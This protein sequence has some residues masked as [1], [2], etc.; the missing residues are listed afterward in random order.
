MRPRMFPAESFAR[1]T[2]TAVISGSMKAIAAWVAVEPTFFVATRSKNHVRHSSFV[3]AALSV[4]VVNMTAPFAV[5]DHGPASAPTTARERH[6]YEP[7]V[8]SG[9]STTCETVP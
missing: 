4:L 9:V 6:R 8:D 1:I 7:F 3:D 2:P 5:S